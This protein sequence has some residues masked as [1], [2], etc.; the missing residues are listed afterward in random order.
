MTKWLQREW[1]YCCVYIS[2]KR[3]KNKRTQINPLAIVDHLWK[4]P[5]RRD[6]HV[7]TETKGRRKVILA[8]GICLA[9][10]FFRTVTSFMKGSECQEESLWRSCFVPG[11]GALCKARYKKLSKIGRTCLLGCKGMVVMFWYQLLSISMLEINQKGKNIFFSMKKMWCRPCFRCQFCN[12][13]LIR[14]AS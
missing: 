13:Y 10:D 8:C 1:Q 2:H 12:K 7:T 4:L 5:L 6:C 9:C 11:L 3:L 14:T